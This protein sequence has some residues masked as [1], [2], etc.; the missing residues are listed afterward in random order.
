MIK[1][2]PVAAW[3]KHHI[4]KTESAELQQRAGRCFAKSTLL[5]NGVSPGKAPLWSNFSPS[6]ATLHSP[7]ALFHTHLYTHRCVCSRRFSQSATGLRNQRAALFPQQSRIVCTHTT[8][9][10]TAINHVGEITI[11]TRQLQRAVERSNWILLIFPPLL[12]LGPE[13]RLLLRRTNLEGRG[14]AIKK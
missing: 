13:S 3:W 7:L 8:S 2:L 12:L 6:H 1:H 9:C 14:K 10:I 11:S 5:F 4:I